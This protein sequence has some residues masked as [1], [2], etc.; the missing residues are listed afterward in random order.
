MHESGGDPYILLEAFIALWIVFLLQV[1]C[2]QLRCAETDCPHMGLCVYSSAF[3]RRD[4][5]LRKVFT[6]YGCEQGFV[7]KEA[8]HFP[9]M[10][11]GL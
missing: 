8:V 7:G 9:E 2:I 6:D 5:G 3:V 1:F 10:V 11:F 4:P